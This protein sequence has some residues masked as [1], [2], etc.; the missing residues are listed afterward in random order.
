MVH[1][2]KVEIFG[3]KSFGFKNTTVQFEPGLV[4]ISGPNGSGKSNILDAI[5]FA[6]GENK[7]KVMRVDRLRSLIHDIEGANRR[8]PKMAR[9]SVHFDNSDRKIPVDS[10]IVEI[11]REMDSNGENTYYLNKKKTN[12][13]HILD[14]LDM[15]NAGLGQLNA[16]QQG[17]VT[18][19]SE[20]TSEEK[21]KTIE[22]LIGLSSFDDKK[23]ESMKQLEEADR[24]L[25]IAMAKMGEIKNR[26]DDLE[27]ERNQK[28]RHDIVERELNRYRAI[29]A[30]NKMKMISAR[31]TSKETTL[32]AMTT[33]ITSFDSERTILRTE[34]DSLDS[35]KSKLMDKANDFNQAKAVLDS[36]ISAAMEQYE[37]DNTAISASKKRLEQIDIRIPEIKIELQSIDSARSGIDL[38]IQKIKESLL[39]T[40]EKKNNINKTVEEIDSKRNQVL[41]E[42]SKA[43]SKKSEIDTKIKTLTAQLN[44]SKLKLSKIQHETNESKNKINANTERFSELDDAISELSNS[45]TKLESLMNNHNATIVELKLRIQKLQDKK[46]KITNDLEEW[47]L[48][49]EKS[50]KAATHYES[51]IKTVKGYMH[52]DYTVAKLKE[53]ADKL[54]IEGLVYE[55]VSWDKK[56]ERPMMAVSSDWIKAIVV[57]DF[58]TLLGIAEIARSKKLHKL[59]II[60]LDSIPKF[61]I[62]L[63]KISGVI[64]VLADYV[65]CNS[66]YAA[67]K[68]FLF[69]NVILTE[70]RETAYEI[71]QS[72]YKAVTLD[73]EYFEAKGGTVVIDINSKISKL[74]KLI[75]MSSEIDV[76]LQSNTLIKKY[77]LR[78][79]YSLKKIDTNTQS[80]AQRLSISEK[81]LTSTTE[82]Y[83]NLKSRIH[84]ALDTKKQLSHR[85]S[86]LTLRN[87]TI[88][89]EKSTIESHVESLNERITLVEENYAS[90]EQARI[91]NEL[92]KINL[93]KIDIEKL[94]STIMAEYREKDSQLT[95]MQTQDNR[96][97]SQINRLTN[98]N[99]ALKSEYG[100]LETKIQNL[101][102]QREPKQ[103]VL[104]KLR[105][106][107]QELISSSG[108]SVGHLKEYDD[109]LKILSEQDKKLTGEINTLERKSD[110]LNR[111]LHD[112]VE[113]EAKLQQILSAFGFDKDMETFDVETIVQGLSTELSSLN[114]LNAKAPETYLDVSYGYRSMSD[115]KNSLEEERNFIVEFMEDI[116]KDKRQTFLDAFDKVDKEIRLIFNKMTGGN[117]WLELQNED[118]IFNSGISYLIQFPNK[119]KREST[120]ISGGEKTLAAIV[121]VLALQKLKPS[122]FYLFD[123]VDAHLD[124]PNSKKLANILEERS[125]ESQFIMV[126]LK[127][128]VIQKAKLI[129]G[130]FPKNGVSHIVTYKDKRMPSVRNS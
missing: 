46:S 64:G 31:K 58:A 22:D 92:S 115:R 72:G 70:T 32:H 73:G 108:S 91:A 83:S 112:L 15:A 111:D 84:S 45:K 27:E 14:L 129:Y 77:T 98:E 50:S 123:E 101:E 69:G 48:I 55:M 85:I 97:K 117:A 29:A 74:T 36:E 19:I 122:P 126:S 80:Y 87:S 60:P 26:I 8:G 41:A 95:K 16:V 53:D 25:E 127:D 23:T 90:G 110:S 99:D 93:R 5:I 54:G 106:K 119:P 100:E 62:T 20:F 102:K 67:L 78:Q 63:P 76:L 11:T 107:E 128:S 6:M 109:K 3:F 130:V 10:D 39:D 43:A 116:E 114:S 21:R 71:S 47:N 68:T 35:E 57:K 7:P 86:E 52:E 89:S 37:I 94:Y 121:F 17:T 120:S 33:E 44:D 124:A 105:E 28:L 75:S 24:R 104:V 18:R 125:K 13:S 81:Q 30:A 61:Q 4:S 1:V 96:E 40:T 118:D 66:N 113:S 88:E 59:K 82:N 42:Q 38:E 12:R 65:S 103:E 56:Y 51:K 34:I 49:L 9:S 2:K 79:K